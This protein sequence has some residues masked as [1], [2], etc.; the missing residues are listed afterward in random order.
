MVI[1][2]ISSYLKSRNTKLLE[3]KTKRS[4][5]C[6]LINFADYVFMQLYV[7][8]SFEDNIVY[9]GFSLFVC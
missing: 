4:P 9:K 2:I 7:L 5:I 6:S 3:K 1:D 8:T